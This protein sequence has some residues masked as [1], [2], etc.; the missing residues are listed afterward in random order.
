M[1]GAQDDKPVKE[2]LQ[3]EL[4]SDIFTL[5]NSV[6]DSNSWWFGD[7]FTVT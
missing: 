2:R 7:C 5:L 3:S 1:I 6:Y 4:F